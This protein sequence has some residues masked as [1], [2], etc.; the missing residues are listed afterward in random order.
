MCEKPHNPLRKVKN[1]VSHLFSLLFFYIA[2]WKVHFP[3]KEKITQAKRR[4]TDPVG[5]IPL[6]AQNQKRRKPSCSLRETIETFFP[7]SYLSL[8]LDGY[9]LTI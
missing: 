1:V 6:K 3:I 5:Y 9:F 4:T 8:L 2:R 7:S